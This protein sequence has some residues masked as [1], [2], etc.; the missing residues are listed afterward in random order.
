MTG[1]GWEAD[2]PADDGETVE[3]CSNGQQ[4]KPV[5]TSGGLGGGGGV[6]FGPFNGGGDFHDNSAGCSMADFDALIELIESTLADDA[7]GD[8]G[9]VQH[10][11]FRVDLS[12]I[13][14]GSQERH[15][16]IADLL[17]QLR[18]L[19]SLQIDIPVRFVTLNDTFFEELGVE[20]DVTDDSDACDDTTDVQVVSDDGDRDALKDSSAD[21]RTDATDYIFSGADLDFFR[22]LEAFRAFDQ[23]ER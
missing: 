13:E 6:G 18:K 10:E 11:P 2:A 20:F 3:V 4:T 8:S 9:V 15:E 21:D 17:S 19:Q 16:R 23:G 22:E 1:S 5:G 7:S 12:L 14:Q